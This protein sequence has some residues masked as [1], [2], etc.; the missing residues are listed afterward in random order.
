[1]G[2][3]AKAMV[4]PAVGDLYAKWYEVEIKNAAGDLLRR[5][6]EAFAVPTVDGHVFVRSR[7]E[8]AIVEEAIEVAF[9]RICTIAVLHAGEGSF[10]F[11]SAR[12][13]QFADEGSLEFTFSPLE[14]LVSNEVDTEVIPSPGSPPPYR[15][16][17]T[18]IVEKILLFARNE[19]LEQ[20]ERR[21]R[22]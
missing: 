3:D 7:P 19:A 15:D 21:T 10:V 11:R 17:V 16:P 22:R 4:A 18:M 14:G 9:N 20:E 12:G 13:N 2:R 5:V 1:M 8:R 6:A